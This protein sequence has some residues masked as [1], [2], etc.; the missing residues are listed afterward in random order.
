VPHFSAAIVVSAKPWA[1]WELVGDLNRHPAWSANDLEVTDLGGGRF[2]TVATTRGR[3]FTAEVEVLRSE[4]ERLFEFRATDETGTYLHR[5]YLARQ[6]G[7]TLVKRTVG[8]ERL[9]RLQRVLAWV[10]LFPVRLP[11]LRKSLARLGEAAVPE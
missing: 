4:P 5:V 3:T 2:R 8:P 6:G 9:S 11:A 1:V 10:I 7:G